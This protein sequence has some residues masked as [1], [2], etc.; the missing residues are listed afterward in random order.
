MLKR[1][2][3]GPI[4]HVVRFAGDRLG[5]V[6]AA[7]NATGYGLTV[8]LHSRVEATADFVA[9]R[10]K[11]GNLVGPSTGTLATIVSQDPIYVTFQASE[12]DVIAYRKRVPAFLPFRKWT[13]S[14]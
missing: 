9:E 7:I 1:E 6:C 12:A 10:V 11:V 5:E 3:F 14:E 13:S 2:V 4:L 8:G